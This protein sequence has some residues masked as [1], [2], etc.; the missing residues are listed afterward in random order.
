MAFKK[1]ESTRAKTDPEREAQK[2]AAEYGLPDVLYGFALG[3]LLM[4]ALGS[5]IGKDPEAATAS[6]IAAA[7]PAVLWSLRRI[8]L[9]DPAHRERLRKKR[10]E[11]AKRQAE[12]ESI[13]RAVAA[14][15]ADGGE[16]ESVESRPARKSS[17]QDWGCIG[18]CLSILLFPILVIIELAK[19]K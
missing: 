5:V 9:R 11:A 16:A 8:R 12:Y 4:G 19:K 17:R 7:I 13:R 3:I 1:R 10:E 18:C 14:G 15:Q 6:L 2:D